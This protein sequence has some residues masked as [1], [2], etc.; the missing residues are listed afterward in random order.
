V[1]FLVDN[2]LPP[3]LARFLS[4]RGHEA[5]HVLDVG[6]AQSAGAKI[7]SFAIENSFILVSKD[8]DFLNLLHRTT[9]RGRLIWVQ[10]GNCRTPALLEAVERVWSSIEN[11]FAAGE[12]VVELR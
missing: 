8:Q 6:L 9:P 2:Q 10:L 11:L 7:W 3:A 5:V 4:G 1:K 12:R